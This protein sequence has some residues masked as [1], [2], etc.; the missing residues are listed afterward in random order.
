MKYLPLVWNGLWRR[1][2]QTLFTLASIAVAFIL[3]GILA[4]IDAGF[5]HT[6]AASRMDRLFTDPRFGAPMP[7][8]YGEQIAR[9]PGVSV[10]APRS[11]LFG[12]FQDPK[13]TLGVLCSDRR[14]FA[15][16]P[17]ISISAPQIELLRQMRTGAAVSVELASKFGWKVG[18]KVPLQTNTA[19]ADGSRVWTF[20]IVAIVDDLNYPGQGG[21]FIA[22]YQYLDEGRVDG[23]STI[24]RFLVRISDPRRGAQIGREIDQRF[25]NS[26]APTRTNSERSQAQSGLQFIGD[27]NFLTDAVLGAVFFMLLFL[28]GNTLLQSVRERTAEFAMLK[29][30][31][32][33]NVAVL[34]LV[35]AESVLLCLLAATAG[36]VMSEL[37][38][39]IAHDALANFVVLLQMPWRAMLRGFALALIVALL[40]SLLPAWRVMQLNVVNALVRR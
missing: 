28:S 32:F 19:Q 38:I 21:W 11:L 22:N 30:L 13:N 8:S 26:A 2:A 4:G 12:Y 17:E 9:V 10:V 6:L 15:L 5:A 25:A 35:I 14:F 39:P 34:S 40:G 37:L 33:S 29:A 23:K 31:G 7:M 20:D 36:L 18:D 16:R 1:R 3:F 27:V 24:D